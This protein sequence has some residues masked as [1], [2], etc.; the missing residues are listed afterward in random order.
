M[1]GAVCSR[2]LPTISASLSYEDLQLR[3][4]VFEFKN[5]LKKTCL[6]FLITKEYKGPVLLSLLSTAFFPMLL[7]S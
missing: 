5:C 4:I 6:I 7:Y 2:H 1:E 3:Q